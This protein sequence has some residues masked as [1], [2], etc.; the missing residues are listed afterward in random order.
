MFL[1]V[2]AKLGSL[3]TAA[4]L[5]AGFLGAVLVD[6]YTPAL[7]DLMGGFAGSHLM[8]AALLFAAGAAAG[9]LP[10]W[11]LS[12]VASGLFLGLIDSAFGLVT[13]ALAGMF[14]ITLLLL[15]V[16]PMF[17]R[18]EA[19]D[20]W[21]RSRVVR[22]LHETLENVF[23]APRFRPRVIG[24][25]L[26]SEAERAVEPI[27]GKARDVAAET[28]EFAREKAGDVGRDIRKKLK[29]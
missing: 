7:A 19:S 10:G 17:P 29:K 1:G 14:A 13:G 26:E 22:P 6:Y 3:W 18:V 15:A 20:G 23:N 12:R 8:A 24:E 21:K 11:V 27:A 9:L 25:R 16:P 4:C 28:A 5:V 2:G